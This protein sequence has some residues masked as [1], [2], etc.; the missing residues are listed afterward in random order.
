MRRCLLSRSYREAARLLE[1][2]LLDM[3]PLTTGTTARHVQLFAYYACR[4]LLGMGRYGDAITHALLGLTAPAQAPSAIMLATYKLYLLT[5]LLANGENVL[6]VLLHLLCGVWVNLPQGCT[7]AKQSELWWLSYGY[8]KR[9][10]S[11]S[12]L[13]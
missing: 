9:S 3:D 11:S 12:N 7:H 10:F 13:A 8:H 6:L 2:P 5:S 4:V 1:A